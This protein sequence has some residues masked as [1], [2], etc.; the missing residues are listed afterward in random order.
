MDG[1]FTAA[2]KI[3]GSLG[4]GLASLTLDHKYKHERARR[5]AQEAQNVSDGIV[6]VSKVLDRIADQQEN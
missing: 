3:T 4:Q 1:T 6:R 2:S 5:K